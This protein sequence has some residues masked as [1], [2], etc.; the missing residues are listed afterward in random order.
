MRRYVVMHG[1]VSI[2]W[3]AVRF[4][5][6][7]LF[8]RA[9]SNH[10]SMIYDTLK[11]V[12]LEQD[13][14]PAFFHDRM[15]C[16]DA[17]VVSIDIIIRVLLYMTFLPGEAGS[18]ISK[19]V[20]SLRLL[21]LMRLFRLVRAIKVVRVFRQ[22]YRGGADI[23]EDVSEGITNIAEILEDVSEGITNITH[24]FLEKMRQVARKES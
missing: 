23:L 24:M 19:L 1:I 16:L 14:I 17:V 10:A 22:I 9:F 18:S 15:N 21:R 6:S 8:S 20:K 11:I 5:V 12:R 2:L 4:P 3:K 13:H 7:E